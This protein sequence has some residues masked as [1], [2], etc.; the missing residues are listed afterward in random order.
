MTSY[1]LLSIA[2]IALSSSLAM[3]QT[4]PLPSGTSDNTPKGPNDC[5]KGTVARDMKDNSMMK[6]D[7]M[8]RSPKGV[9]CMPISPMKK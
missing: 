9:E 2:V 3:A 4:T 6:S 1:K 5:P 8:V 7:K